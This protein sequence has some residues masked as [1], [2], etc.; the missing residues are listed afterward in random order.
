MKNKILFGT[1][2]LLLAMT[3]IPYTAMAAG[4]GTLSGG[5]YRSM[6]CD[7]NYDAYGAG[8]VCRP[9]ISSATLNA[10]CI[11]A[12][13]PA[14]SNSFSCTSGCYKASVPVSTCPTV[15]ITVSGTDYIVPSLSIVEYNSAKQIWNCVTKTLSPVSYWQPG[16]T[17]GDIYYSG[18]DV[19]VGTTSTPAKFNVQAAHG[20]TPAVSILNS[21]GIAGV[22][23]RP[24][25]SGKYNTFVGVD[26]G[27]NVTAPASNSA[28]GYQSFAAAA[29]GS[30]NSALG[31]QT[32]NSNTS[33][34]NNVAV[35]GEA[36]R[37]NTTGNENTAVGLDALEYNTTGGLNVAIG[38][39]SLPL[40]TTGEY[41]TAIGSAA[42]QQNTTG[43]NNMGIGI[44][45]VRNGTTASYNLGIGN[46]ALYGNTTGAKNIGVGYASLY[47][48]TTGEEN[49][50]LGLRAGDTI[51]T[52]SDNTFIGSRADA[53][54]PGLTN[55]T[56]IG[57]DAV[58]SASNSLVLGNNVNVGIGTSTPSTKLDVNGQIRIRGGSP[59]AGKVLISTADGTAS[60]TTPASLT[61]LP[62]VA[63][64][65]NYVT[66]FIGTNSVGNSIIYDNG[67]NVGIG[68]TTPSTKLDVNGQIR[69]RSGSPGAGKVLTSDASGLAT[70]TTPAAGPTVSGT[71]NYLPKF[72]GTTAL[73][74][75]I[76]FEGTSKI[77]IGTNTPVNKLDVE[78]GMVIGAS[79]SG[80]TS[81][82]ANGLSV[83]GITTIR[84][85]SS[86]SGYVA[87]EAYPLQVFGHARVNGALYVSDNIS[88]TRDIT[89]G[90]ASSVH[91]IY[92]RIQSVDN[93]MIGPTGGTS[94][95][96]SVY[97]NAYKNSGSTWGSTSDA[98]LKDI[99]G[100]FE[101]GL[102]E[103]MKLNPIEFNYKADNPEGYPSNSK[104]TQIGL[105][106]QDVQKVFP[107]AVTED[108]KG[109]LML[110][111]HPIYIAF[112]NAIQQLKN[113]QDTSYAELKAENALLETRIAALE[114]KMK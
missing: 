45:T 34:R 53:S 82:P 37:L 2:V 24:G 38:S 31:Y 76:I 80:T 14:D 51:T 12:G 49:T 98:R 89:A 4:N 83:Q 79:Y 111:A 15:K 65:A 94:G 77:G 106:A 100:S 43:S 55:A 3:T 96:L 26:A 35:G 50:A 42:L 18:G 66:K 112:I 62:S 11:T 114:A 17:A 54:S 16:A 75:S 32:L 30:Y 72:T 6:D 87:N 86:S 9:P 52:G 33:G 64:T 95:V 21:D 70:W 10:N 40:N 97:G 102:N 99:H 108:E 1:L 69:I 20:T 60:W 90:T 85:N 23:M 68:T 103:I 110:N 58:V 73:G 7:S 5:C 93:I 84:G 105:I 59:A 25:G 63:G 101:K 36:L 92:G 56:A 19:S 107:E 46:W 8:A 113:S 61:G 28:F 91:N 57:S 104:D 39:F 109:Y 22:E 81:A 44:F 78:G 41:N 47:N 71:T 67:T 74:N 29:T 88:I 27:E 13:Y 48:V